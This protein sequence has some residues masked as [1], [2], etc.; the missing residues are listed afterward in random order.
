MAANLLPW[1]RRALGAYFGNPIALRD[2]RTQ[3]RGVKAL[4]LWGTYLFFLILIAVLFYLSILSSGSQVSIA[5]VQ[6]ELHTFYQRL[7]W[8]L[9]GTVAMITPAFTA[10][11]VVAE[12]QH[13]SFDLLFSTPLRLKDF[14]VG[15]MLSSYRYT[16]MLLIL[17]LPVTAVGVMLGGATWVDV[18]YAYLLLSVIGLFYSAVG[19]LISTLT[20]KPV[21]AVIWTYAVVGIIVLVTF[22]YYQVAYFGPA[23]FG[24]P[25]I[26]NEFPLQGAFST[27][28]VVEVAPTHSL[29][30]GTEVP[31]LILVCVVVLLL[32]KLLVLGAASALSPYAS[33][34][35]KSLRVHGLI[36]VAAAALV[37]GYGTT[38]GTVGASAFAGGFGPA[39]FSPGTPF[40][41]IWLGIDIMLVTGAVLA[42]LFIPRITCHGRDAERRSRPDGIF[43][44]RRAFLGTPS[45]ALPYLL[46]LVITA[47]AGA[48]AGLAWAARGQ[49]DLLPLGLAVVATRV[50]WAAGCLVFAWSLGRLASVWT[51]KVGV[52][53]ALHLVILIGLLV[54]PIPM[55]SLL[56]VAGPDLWNVHPLYVHGSAGTAPLLWGTALL[57]V[58]VVV[59]AATRGNERSRPVRLEE[60]G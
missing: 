6:S 7:M 40:S 26:T 16:W 51:S 4:V 37:I 39:A 57:F 33:P 5:F 53:R 58:G 55:L 43:N 44:S 29:L 30:F 10:A 46:L 9:G 48:A 49:P 54:L 15:R 42:L 28:G 24:G 27:F 11:S 14:L 59:A 25:S 21:S 8:L 50:Y 56:S 45:G 47:G 2:Y 1:A 18:I 60:R 31:N 17:S 22:I 20:A 34:E 32:V 35:T 13:G 12:R 3:L 19:L 36:Y 38:N 23:F 52:A 41:D